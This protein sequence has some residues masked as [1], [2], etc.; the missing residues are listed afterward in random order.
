[1]PLFTTELNRVANAIVD[2]S[3]VL[4][5]HDAAP[6][7]A[8]PAN[9]RRGT[10]QTIA[11]G[12]WS[13]ASGGDVDIEDDQTFGVIDAANARTLS[14]WSYYKSGS[15]VAFGTISPSVAVTAGG[16]FTMNGGTVQINGATS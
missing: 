9:G 4:Y 12:D 1:M 11:A 14:H 16:T 5:V 15:P 6:T 3:G 10:G 2:A 7:N 13:A 8:S